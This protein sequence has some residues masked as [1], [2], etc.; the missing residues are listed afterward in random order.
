MEDLNEFVARFDAALYDQWEPYPRASDASI[1][2]I[3]ER[4]RFKVPSLLAELAQNSDRYSNLF[5][6]LGTD[7]DNHSHIISKN[8]YVRSDHEWL[9]LG[10]RAP[11]NLVFIT[12][13]FMESVFWCLDVSHS[14]KEYPVVRWSPQ[15]GLGEPGTRYDNF[16]LFV[17]SQV[18][19]YERARAC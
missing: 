13:N 6:S 12:E 16:E 3:E 4:L 5:L 11:D 15:D 7:I 1:A 2:T 8:A 14:G 9:Q 19:F 17:R 18:E 10:P